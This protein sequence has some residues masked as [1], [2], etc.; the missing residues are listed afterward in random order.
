M[1]A[2]YHYSRDGQSFGPVPVEQLR[3]LAAKGQ[4][5]ATDLV[6]KEGMAEWVPAGRFKGLIPAAPVVPVAVTPSADA[7]HEFR[8]SEPAP[9]PVI[10][11]VAPVVRPSAA[12]ENVDEVSQ[13]EVLARGERSSNGRRQRRLE[14][15]QNIGDESDRRTANG[16]R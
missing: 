16:G 7:S 4:L 10:P 8:L 15:V 13:A 14:G 5:S 9:A 2:D 3:E 11:P 1:A 6:W 12:S